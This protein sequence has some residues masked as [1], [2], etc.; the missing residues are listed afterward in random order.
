MTDAAE[1]GDAAA[2]FNLGEYYEK[3]EGVVEDVVETYK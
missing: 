2:Q 3:G 1:Q